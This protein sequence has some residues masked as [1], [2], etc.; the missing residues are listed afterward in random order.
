MPRSKQL[1]LTL[2]IQTKTGYLEKLKE[3][4]SDLTIAYKNENICPATA[5]KLV[6]GTIQDRVRENFATNDHVQQNLSGEVSDIDQLI[7][8]LETG[9]NISRTVREARINLV[10]WGDR[11][12]N[13]GRGNSNRGN[14][15]NNRGNF[16]NNRGNFNN[17]NNRGN[18]NYRGNFSN[19]N[20]Y[21]GNNR[22]G[23]FNNNYNNDDNNIQYR[24]NNN[25]SRGNSNSS[26]GNNDS[27]RNVRVVKT[28]QQS[29][30]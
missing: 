20:N 7:M 17:F 12:T 1:F 29:E 14:F 19:N 18:N 30:N 23:N 9:L 28:P 24:N 27:R 22:R 5:R 26:R 16:N 11:Q 21:R 25:Y 10:R 6:T 2:L 8:N 15:H 4:E 3:I 13:R